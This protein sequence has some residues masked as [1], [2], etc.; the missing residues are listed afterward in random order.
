M[1]DA[2]RQAIL[3]HPHLGD[4]ECAD[5]ID[6]TWRLEAQAQHWRAIPGEHEGMRLPPDALA[7]I[8]VTIQGRGRYGYT[9]NGPNHKHEEIQ[10]YVKYALRHIALNFGQDGDL[11]EEDVEIEAKHYREL[12]EMVRNGARG[13]DLLKWFEERED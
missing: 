9:W 5:L 2:L 12:R 10:R 4:Q 13:E 8:D 11:Y 1:S 7:T 6:E 3:T